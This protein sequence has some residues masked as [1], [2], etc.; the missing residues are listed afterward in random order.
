M[1][2]DQKE[3]WVVGIFLG[4][5][6]HYVHMNLWGRLM[7]VAYPEWYLGFAHRS[8]ELSLALWSAMLHSVTI[9]ILVIPTAML[10]QFVLKERA[11]ATALVLAITSFI[12]ILCF[13]AFT[14]NWFF[15]K[16]NINTL[17]SFQWQTMLFWVGYS[18]GPFLVVL[19]LQRLWKPKLT[20]KSQS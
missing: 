5:I 14:F 6:Y 20:T 7:A 17:F 11:K 2:I 13:P 19:L 12:L 4:A 10:L 15:L 3:T 16:M 18:I 1:R 9:L 8:P